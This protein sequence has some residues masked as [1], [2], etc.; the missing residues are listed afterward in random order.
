MKRIAPLLLSACCLFLAGQQYNHPFAPA[1][2][3]TPDYFNDMEVTGNTNCE[4]EDGNP[5]AGGI[6]EDSTPDCDCQSGTG[7][8]PLE[9]SESLL[10]LDSGDGRESVTFQNAWTASNNIL[11]RVRTL[12][13][14]LYNENGQF[15]AFPNEPNLF[16]GMNADGKMLT[17]C[18]GDQSTS[19]GT[20]SADTEYTIDCEIDFSAGTVDMTAYDASGT[21]VSN[22]TASCDGTDAQTEDDDVRL[23]VNSIDDLP[24]TGVVIDCLEVYED[25]T[26][27]PSAGASCTSN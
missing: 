15:I 13:E 6:V 24:S 12:L 16:C 7:N 25:A 4:S 17:Q 9:S 26:A 2:G 20:L 22:G 3:G 5:A 14:D 19:T 8:C 1:A 11:V 23:G 10:L 21:P 27:A 18:L